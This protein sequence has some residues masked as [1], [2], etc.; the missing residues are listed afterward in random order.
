VR[1]NVTLKGAG[2]PALE[3]DSAPV[4]AWFSAAGPVLLDDAELL[5]E[6]DEL[7]LELELDELREDELE[8]DVASPSPPPSPEQPARAMAETVRMARKARLR[9]DGRWPG[10]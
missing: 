2:P 10:A 8:L 7:E 3:A 9:M 4:G 5:E 1:S 6:L